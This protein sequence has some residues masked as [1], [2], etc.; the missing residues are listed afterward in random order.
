MDISCHVM[1]Y[2]LTQETRIRYAF[3]DVAR[4]RY[5]FDGVANTIHQTQRAGVSQLA[6]GD[7]LHPLRV[8]GTLRQRVQKRRLRGMAIHNVLTVCS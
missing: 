1:G 6:Q 3:D 8:P 5:A 7:Q 2:H 4:I